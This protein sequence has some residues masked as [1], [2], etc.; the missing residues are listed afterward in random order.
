VEKANVFRRFG[1]W[2]RD[3]VRPKIV[4]PVA[5]IILLIAIPFGARAQLGL[6]PCCAIISAG[7]N[8]ISGL[9]SNVVAAPLKSIQQIQQQTSTFE[10][11]VIYPA[12]AIANATGLAT[13]IQGQLRQT[14]QLYQLSI[15]SATLPTP[16]QLEQAVLSHNPQA[17]GQITQSYGALYGAVMPSTDAPQNVRDLVDMTDAEAQAALKKAVELDALA[18]T[19]IAAANQINQQL[20]NATPGSAPI[21]E[22]EAAAWLVRSNAYTQSAMAELVRVRSIGLANSSAQLKFSTAHTNDLQNSVGHTLG[23]E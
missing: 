10:Q 17:F 15:S 21:L 23:Q 4:F 16:Q 6:D 8:A 20:Q 1:R 11:Q 13:Q 7:L 3:L 5:V 9:L 22:A 14:S 2:A 18:D 19:E 12:S